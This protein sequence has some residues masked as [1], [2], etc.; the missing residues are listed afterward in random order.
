MGAL[1]AGA[2]QPQGCGRAGLLRRLRPRWR[3]ARRTGRRRRLA[4]DDRDLLCDSQG[5]TRPRSL[6]GTLLAGMASAHHACH[7]GGR[8]PRQA[9]RRSGSRLDDPSARKQ[10]ERKESGAGGRQ[11]AIRSP[12]LG[13]T[14]PAIRHLLARAIF[15][16]PT[17]RSGCSDGLTGACATMPQLAIP[18]IV[19]GSERN[20]RYESGCALT[21][22]GDSETPLLCDP[23]TSGSEPEGMDAVDTGKVYRQELRGRVLVAHDEGG[24]VG[25][26]A[27]RFKVSVS[28]VSKVISRRERK[29]GDR[30]PAANKSRAR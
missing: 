25:Q 29:R 6:R 19:G 21:G 20:C 15:L 16:K 12:Q 27:R 10:T 23:S 5:R 22:I 8:V 7:G 2:P 11:F 30:C 17:T 26:I 4:L 18:I 14:V 3:N 28:Y 1:A 24:R 9:A 13:V